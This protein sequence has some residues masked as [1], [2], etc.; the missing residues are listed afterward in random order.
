MATCPECEVDVEVDEFDVDPGDLLSCS[1]CGAHLA[2][3]AV[4]PLVL[5]LADEDSS[6]EVDEPAGEE[7]DEDWE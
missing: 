5:A 6:L 3:S 7:G 4:V 2:V 1:E